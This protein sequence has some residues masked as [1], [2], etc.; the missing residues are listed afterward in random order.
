MPGEVERK[1]LRQDISSLKASTCH[2]W[3]AT[4][5]EF[6]IKVNQSFRDRLEAMVDSKG[7]CMGW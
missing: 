5:A 4:P 2:V 7:G 1:A 6:F 3:D